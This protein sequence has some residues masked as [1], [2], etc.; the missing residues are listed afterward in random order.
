MKVSVIIPVYNS[1][2]YLRTCLESLLAQTFGDWEA[3]VVDDGSTD[4]SGEL[5][6]EFARRDSRIRLLTREHKG[7]SAARNLA[8]DAA[9]GEYLFFL[10][11]DDAIHPR[12]LE[13][14]VTQA[15]AS[16]S[17]MAFCLFDWLREEDVEQA[18]ARLDH[19]EEPQWKI[20][21][22]A[23]AAEQFHSNNIGRLIEWQSIGGKLI[24][25]E[26]LLKLRFAEDISRG[27]DTLLLYRIIGRQPKVCYFLQG[28]Y[29]YRQHPDSLMGNTVGIDKVLR[30]IVQAEYQQGR[31]KNASRW[32]EV[33]C[34]VLTDRIFL[35]EE[36]GR[37]DVAGTLRQRLREERRHPLYRRRGFVCK[38][39]VFL[40]LYC[41]PL[42]HLVKLSIRCLRR[43]ARRMRSR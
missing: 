22:A 13:A 30:I 9:A 41:Y 36:A 11:S 12:L 29:Y 27:E 35:A 2:R 8:M 26:L 37:K 32:Q 7:V 19:G 15:E 42:F 34:E 21:S 14:L 39:A 43:L 23:Q 3:L 33:L 20:L 6:R 4:G 10:D 38:T 31:V 16:G 1:A 28:W 40:C 25:S 17:Q 18:A 5:C 24:Q